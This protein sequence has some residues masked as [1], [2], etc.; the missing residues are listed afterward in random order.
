[1]RYCKNILKFLSFMCFLMGLI[2]GGMNGFY[3]CSFF[4]FIILYLFGITDRIEK[5]FGVVNNNISNVFK[6]IVLIFVYLSLYENNITVYNIICAI[7][8]VI[9]LW[10][11]ILYLN[12][13]IETK[14]VRIYDSSNLI[15]NKF[16]NYK[17]PN[18]T[19]LS[20]KKINFEEFKDEKIICQ[21]LS[22]LNI[23]VKYKEKFQ[24]TWLNSYKFE[25][26]SGTSID[27][28]LEIKKDLEV[29][30]ETNVEIEISGNEK[31]IIYIRVSRN[32]EDILYLR[33]V[34]EDASDERFI[35]LGEMDDGNIKF[36]DI[37]EKSPLLLIGNVGTGKTSFIN[38]IINTLLLKYK[39]TELNMILIDKR[40]TGLDIYDKIPHLVLP[41]L[42]SP[43]KVGIYFDLI[44]EE[45]E[46]RKE[47]QT[48]LEPLVVIIDE[49]FDIEED[50]DILKDKLSIIIAEG[51]RNRVYLIISTSITTDN[52]LT[53]YLYYNIKNHIYFCGR[54][55]EKYIEYKNDLSNT[56]G[57]INYDSN[58]LRTPLINKDEIKNITDYVKGLK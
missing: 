36:I 7:I 19:L 42:N 30:L 43:N 53:D 20:N 17:I 58:R 21:L 22:E 25:I 32:N 3:I 44:I 14:K 4:I 6:L 48:N 12:L 57:V 39:P 34:L 37:F 5:K 8:C 26:E 29:K 10:L 47:E 33:R 50:L 28:I 35:P 54:N 27:Y 2:Y 55:K 11:L 16:D 46:R 23:N 51:I 18:I 40:Q 38:V 13:D 15:K 49:V 9:I 56:V 45:I 1:M 52:V 31:N 41:L 24:N